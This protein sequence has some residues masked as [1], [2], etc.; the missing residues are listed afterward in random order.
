M[1]ELRR[2]LD[3]L[4]TYHAFIAILTGGICILLPHSFIESL[5]GG[6]YNHMIHE[7]VRLYGSLIL[8]QGMECS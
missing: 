3:L 4:F 8:A 6:T 1:Q 2:K 7:V 5:N